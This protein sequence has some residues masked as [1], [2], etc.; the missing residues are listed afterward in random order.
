MSEYAVT[1][2][3]HVQRFSALRIAIGKEKLHTFKLVGTTITQLTLA[4]VTVSK[5][6]LETHGITPLKLTEGGI[7][8]ITALETLE[9]NAKAAKDDGK[10]RGFF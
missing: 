6:A 8:L 1:S 2:K 7:L 5:K 10:A 3:G 9:R 4:S